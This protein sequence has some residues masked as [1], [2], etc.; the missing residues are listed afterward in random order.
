M[1]EKEQILNSE[2]PY[3]KKDIVQD[4]KK[5]GLK[6]G[7]VVLVHS[8]LSKIGWVIGREISIIQALLEVVGPEG[9]IVMPS[10][11]TGNS[12]P[13]YW[14]EPQV[15]RD[16]L[17]F[18]KENMPSFDPAYAP[19]RNMGRIAD[20]FYR[21]PGTIRSNH[22]QVSFSA[23]GKCAKEITENHSLSFG[24][25]KH[26]PL[27]KLY[28]LDAK[29]LL[30]G[31]GYEVCT[32]MHLAESKQPYILTETQG[33]SLKS[34]WTE[35]EEIVYD[36]SDFA[37]IGLDFE[38]EKSVNQGFIG[39]AYS[40][41]FSLPEVV[42]FAKIWI[43]KNRKSLVNIPSEEFKNVYYS[44]MEKDFPEDELKPLERIETNPYSHQYGYYEKGLKGY[45]VVVNVDKYCLLDYFAIFPQYRKEGNGSKFLEILLDQFPNQ[46]W[47]IESE[48]PY[49][50]TSERRLQ[51]YQKNGWILSDYTIV[52]YGVD[53]HILSN[54]KLGKEEIDHAYS[55]FYA[56]EFKKEHFY[57]VE[58]E[59]K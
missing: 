24:L 16:W 34:G 14:Q 17:D 55:F 59:N 23:N 18:I 50:E 47:V 44:H 48:V 45:A 19:T 38:K 40:R 33:S 56:P 39:Q 42:D 37:W 32:A 11:S 51:F 2:K 15:P 30:L 8:S 21:Y 10:H 22:P 1:S 20:A 25:G 26:S 4:L 46:T 49:D 54:K 29:I 52:L 41:V 36:D 58:E 3:S 43:Q 6:Q 28:D 27:Q 13:D 7:D 12:M 31:V 57:V 35:F 53:Y 9:T 5:L